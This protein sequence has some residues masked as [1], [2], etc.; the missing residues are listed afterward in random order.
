MGSEMS[1]LY[2]TQLVSE[3]LGERL[4]GGLAR[5]VGSVTRWVRDTLL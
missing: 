5:V 4:H 2:F 1:V 3:A